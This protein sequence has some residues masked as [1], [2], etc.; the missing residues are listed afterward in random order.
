MRLLVSPKELLDLSF[1]DK[2]R[3]TLIGVR[4]EVGDYE[5]ILVVKDRHAGKLTGFMMS[6]AEWNK[7][8][9]GD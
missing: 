9:Y 1:V 3:A 6:E 4:T 7:Y 5:N 8:G 2:T